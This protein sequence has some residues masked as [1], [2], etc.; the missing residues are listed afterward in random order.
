MLTPLGFKS[1]QQLQ[2]KIYEFYRQAMEGFMFDDKATFVHFLNKLN[3]GMNNTS[4][5]HV[6]PKRLI[7]FYSIMYIL[8][9]ENGIWCNF[10]GRSMQIILDLSCIY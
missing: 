2:V 9:C 5:Q 10:Q 4:L 6:D 1:W 3:T 8:I 7:G